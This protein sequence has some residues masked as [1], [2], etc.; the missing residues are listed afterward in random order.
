MIGV[1]RPNPLR[2]GADPGGGHRPWGHRRPALLRIRWRGWHPGQANWTWRVGQGGTGV[3]EGE[4]DWGGARCNSK[5]LS[6]PGIP[7]GAAAAAK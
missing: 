6:L 5:L 4:F 2:A 1:E 7:L 3:G